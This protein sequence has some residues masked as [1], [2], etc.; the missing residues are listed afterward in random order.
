LS[1]PTTAHAPTRRPKRPC[2]HRACSAIT[3]T[4]A[5]DQHP[6][7][8][9]GWAPDSDR[10]SR[11]ERGYDLAW[12]RVRLLVLRR[13]HH[14]CQICRLR[15]A[16]EVDHI[17]PKSDGGSDEPA[18]LQAACTPCHAAKTARETKRR[19]KERNR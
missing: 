10:G 6:R 11:H 5:C 19:G 14:L 16:N 8:T 1:T 12:E 3:T 4:G 7:R 18:N 9:Y 13:D 15:S 17:R 2:W